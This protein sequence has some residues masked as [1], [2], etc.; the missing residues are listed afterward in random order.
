MQSESIMHADNR[1]LFDPLQ[2]SVLLSLLMLS[3]VRAPSQLR[4]ASNDQ[5]SDLIELRIT[6]NQEHVSCNAI[7]QHLFACDAIV[8]ES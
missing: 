7:S 3:H 2:T 6:R 1:L 4:K 5:V 8:A